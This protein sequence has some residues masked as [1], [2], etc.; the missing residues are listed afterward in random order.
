VNYY[1]TESARKA[2]F[3]DRFHKIDGNSQRLLNEEI[4]DLGQLGQVTCAKAYACRLRE[5]VKL[6][7]K[8]TKQ[9]CKG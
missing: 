5:A 2:A 8:W 3:M 7:G 4:L 1:K 9:G 6:P